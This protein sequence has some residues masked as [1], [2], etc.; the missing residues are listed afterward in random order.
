MSSLS[1]EILKQRLDDFQEHKS[2]FCEW[3]VG[4]G[5]FDSVYCYV[6]I[7]SENLYFL[8]VNYSHKI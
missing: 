3:E 1:P 2:N 4:L 8:L 5:G 6:T 7:C